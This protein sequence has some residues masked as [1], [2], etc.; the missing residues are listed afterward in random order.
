MALDKFK[1]SPLPNPPAEYDAQYMRQMIRVLETYHSQLDSRAAN[2]ASAYTADQF[3]LSLGN[4]VTPVEGSLNWNSTDATMDLGLQYGVVMQVGQEMYAR[5]RNDTGVTI[6]NGTV[7]GFAGAGAGGGLSVSPYVADGSSPSEYIVG[8]MTHDFPDNGTFG[9]CTVFGYVRGLD[10]SAFSVGD[11]LYANPSVA[12]EF[13]NVKPTAPNNVITVAAVTISDATEG[14]VFVRPTIIPMEYY[15][16]FSKTD[17]Q[18]PPAINTAYTLTFTTTELSNGVVIGTPT[19][20]LVV[21]QSGVY[22]V[23]ATFQISSTS[24]STKNLWVWYRKNGV[25]V[26]DTARILT[27]NINSG[28][29]PIVMPTTFIMG[30]NDY[31]EVAFAADNTAVSFAS[32]AATAFAPTAPAATIAVTQIQQ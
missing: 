16:V 8:V 9:Y 21:P 2:N 4:T 26:P 10:T 18:S 27:T 32:V 23:D 22:K 3:F 7:V 1:A 15:G 11:I 25:D 28:F 19:S 14:V 13:T 5:V 29:S 17:S 20:R 12:G 31:I 24:A 30:A 6:P